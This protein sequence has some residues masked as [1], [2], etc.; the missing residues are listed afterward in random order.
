MSTETHG[1]VRGRASPP[2]FTLVE[3]LV[4]LAVIGGA[5]T[6]GLPPLTEARR[7][8]GGRDSGLAAV[9]QAQSL[10]DAHAPP[11]AARQGRWQ[12]NSPE[13]AWRVEVGAGEPGPRGVALRPVRVAVGGFVL[14]TL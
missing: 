2:A 7:A 8:K 4:A 5:I 1:G 9:L 13:G 11:G 6:A 14:D 12:G 10:L 3:T